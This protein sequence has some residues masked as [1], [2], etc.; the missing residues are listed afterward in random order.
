MFKLKLWHTVLLP[1]YEN[2]IHPVTLRVI[3]EWI[4]LNP[5]I[6][7][8]RT[9]VNDD[10]CKSF[11]KSFDEE[12]NTNTLKYFKIEENGAFKSDLVRMCLLIKEGGMYMDVDQ[13]PLVPISDYLDFESTDFL[14]GILA[15]KNY[16]C[17]GL[18]YTK[19]PNNR[20]LKACLKYHLET[21]EAMLSGNHEG[22]MSGIHT[23]CKTIR[24]MC[25][26]NH[27]PENETK[28]DGYNCIFLREIEGQHVFLNAFYYKDKPVMMTRYYNYYRDK[29]VKQ[30]HVKFKQK[31]VFNARI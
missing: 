16:T 27:I 29:M 17:N 7:I 25:Q 6:E 4:R 3:N 12:Y 21:Y 8:E 2:K 19:E 22:D 23:M 24:D 31:E 11:L 26:D 18:L 5:E 13:L 14:G 30:E 9:I 1:Q 28:I 10:F 15:P 20:I